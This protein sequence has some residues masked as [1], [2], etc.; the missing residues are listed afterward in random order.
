M[1]PTLRDILVG[2]VSL[3]GLFLVAVLIAAIF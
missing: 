1:N 3:I 2:L